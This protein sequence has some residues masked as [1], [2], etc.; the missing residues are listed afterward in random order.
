MTDVL[1]QAEERA[2]VAV[3]EVARTPR[4]T[5]SQRRRTRRLLLFVLL[6]VVA[7]V[8]AAPFLW[9]LLTA[10]RTPQELFAVDMPL[11]PREWHWENF[12]TALATAPFLTYARNSFVIALTHT[13]SNL[14]LA[15]MAGYALAKI[16]FRGSTVVF[17]F[18][19]ASMM[20]PFY[21]IVIPEFLMVRHVPLAGGNNLFGQDGI[22]WIDSWPALLVPGLV[23]PF[24]IFLFRQF[25]LGT[26][27][28][29]ME[30]SRL[31]GAGEIRIYSRIISPLIKPGMLTVALLAF[32]SGWN[33]FLWPLLVTSRSE[34]RVIQ[35]GLSVF[36][37]EAGTDFNLLMAGTAMAAVPMIVLFAI[38]Q[39]QFVN[40]MVATGIK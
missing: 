36:R 10:V 20:I 1:E 14:V 9:M 37:Q 24:Y 33:N 12:S 34:M 15:S 8:M 6:T 25:Y 3:D 2:A 35:L 28:E 16:R 29:L 32:E 5:A 7:V 38:F 4:R 21:A 27:T 30:A 13:L 11:L 23:S 17:A 22:G 18:V 19:L 40:G 31:D 39:R 26:P